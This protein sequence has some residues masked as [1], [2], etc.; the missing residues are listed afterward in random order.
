MRVPK[1]M[2]P[3]QQQQS[4]S[5]NLSSDFSFQDL[6]TKL[7]QVLKGEYQQITIKQVFNILVQLKKKNHKSS[8]HSWKIPGD[9][10]YPLFH[11]VPASFIM[12]GLPCGA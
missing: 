2:Y 3:T 8:S 5:G 12:K 7:T 1:K 9:Y 10:V 6:Q 4:S 11:P